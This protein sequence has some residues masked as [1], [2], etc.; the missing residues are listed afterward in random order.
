[1][2]KKL[3][4]VLTGRNGFDWFKDDGIETKIFALIHQPT[5]DIFICLVIDS[6]TME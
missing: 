6:G 2:E 3:P 4:D 5:T 1:M